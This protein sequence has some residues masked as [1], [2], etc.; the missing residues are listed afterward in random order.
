M[1]AKAL[2]L[3]RRALIR[4]DISQAEAARQM[5]LAASH[6]SNVLSGTRPLSP[7][8]CVKMGKTL[9]LQPERLAILEAV[10][11]VHNARMLMRK[12]RKRR[13]S[14]TSRGNMRRK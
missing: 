1:N 7:V 4:V 11:Q 13:R 10:E 12:P 14:L 2:K 9:D 6:L 8:M 5:G 3:I